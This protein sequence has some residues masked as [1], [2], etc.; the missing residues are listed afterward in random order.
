MR[1]F[2]VKKRFLLFANGESGISLIETLVA[3]AITGIV[4]VSFLSGLAT[5]S[6]AVMVSQKRVTAEALAKS[7][8][9]YIKAQDYIPT[10]DYNPIDP[11]NSYEQYDIAA[12]LVAAGYTIDINPPTIINS[13]PNGYGF[14]VQSIT[15]M[16]SRNG[17]ELLTVS[18][19]KVGIVTW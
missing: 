1:K 16:I 12:D 5:S 11:I 2:W 15:I 6:T 10:A 18:D 14:E 9:E 7:Q 19:Y 4:A 17:E 8:I 3:L 13:A